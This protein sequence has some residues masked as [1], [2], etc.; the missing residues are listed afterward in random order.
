MPGGRGWGRVPPQAPD[1]PGFVTNH[2]GRGYGQ[3]VSEIGDPINPEDD[4]AEAS[5]TP[6][7]STGD[8]PDVDDE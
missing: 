8:N 3:V 4:E 5:E 6:E 1:A 7:E 2:A